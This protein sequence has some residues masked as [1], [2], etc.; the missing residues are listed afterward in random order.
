MGCSRGLELNEGGHPVLHILLFMEQKDNGLVLI[1]CEAETLD[2]LQG[3]LL[4]EVRWRQEKED[5]LAWCCAGCA[6]WKGQCKIVRGE[7]HF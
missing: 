1:A 5:C 4:L 3:G 6:S 7:S 2:P